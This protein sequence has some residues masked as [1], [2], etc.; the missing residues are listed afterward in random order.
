MGTIMMPFANERHLEGETVTP[1]SIPLGR[2]MT[3]SRPA[4]RWLVPLCSHAM[5]HAELVAIRVAQIGKIDATSCPLPRA[6][7]VL[8]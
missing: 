8:D 5:Q 2:P 1:V 6:W 3:V 4:H 7:L